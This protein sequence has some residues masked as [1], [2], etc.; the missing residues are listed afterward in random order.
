MRVLTEQV[1]D[2]ASRWLDALGLGSGPEALGVH[3]MMGGR[4]RPKEE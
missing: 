4:E 1:A 3:V 2:D